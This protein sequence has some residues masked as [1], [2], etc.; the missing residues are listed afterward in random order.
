MPKYKSVSSV[1]EQPM[2]FVCDGVFNGKARST[3][4]HECSSQAFDICPSRVGVDVEPGR[5]N[6]TYC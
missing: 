6:E 5:A 4:A 2:V 1:N 3:I